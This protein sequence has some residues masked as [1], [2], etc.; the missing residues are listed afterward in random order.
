MATFGIPVVNGAENQV[1]V[2][3]IFFYHFLKISPTFD[4]FCPLRPVVWKHDAGKH[5]E[6]AVR[7]YY[8]V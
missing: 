1:F 2:G 3:Q 7:T 4:I 6:T 5:Y 8:T